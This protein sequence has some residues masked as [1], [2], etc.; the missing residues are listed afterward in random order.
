MASVT[1][2]AF[3]DAASAEHQV[4]NEGANPDCEH[5]PA[6]VCHEEKPVLISALISYGRTCKLT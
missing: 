1:C 4:A 6:I 2:S 5:D 3:F